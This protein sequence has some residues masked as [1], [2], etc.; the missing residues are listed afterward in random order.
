MPWMKSII[1]GDVIIR[2]QSKS[3]ASVIAFITM[4]TTV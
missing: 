2:V 1:K 3:C 4:A